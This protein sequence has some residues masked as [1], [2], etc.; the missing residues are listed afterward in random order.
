MTNTSATTATATETPKVFGIGSD[1]FTAATAH[2]QVVEMWRKDTKGSEL[3]TLRLFET[4]DQIDETG[5]SDKDFHAD[6]CN[7]AIGSGV[8]VEF[9]SLS[10]WGPLVSRARRVITLLNCDNG[11]EA[12]DFLKAW[13]VENVENGDRVIWHVNSLVDMLKDPSPESVDDADDADDADYVDAASDA[14]KVRAAMAILSS[15]SDGADIS[16]VVA[17]CQERTLGDEVDAVFEAVDR[18]FD[19]YTTGL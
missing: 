3:K 5:Q 7:V 15:L 9:P 8:A 12:F 2:E 1:G 4:V 6:A 13:N 17:F 19:F 14:D 16:D 11:A 18:E 10:S